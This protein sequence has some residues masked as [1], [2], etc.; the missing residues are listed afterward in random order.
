M[1]NQTQ[2]QQRRSSSKG[3]AT[4]ANKKTT[5]TP[6][7]V[8][9]Q[10]ATPAG[11]TKRVATTILEQAP[12]H[13]EAKSSVLISVASPDDGNGNA[14]LL[15]SRPNSTPPS[16]NSQ[17]S[18]S[19]SS[20]L[21]SSSSMAMPMAGTANVTMTVTSASPLGRPHAIR[22]LQEEQDPWKAV[23]GPGRRASYAGARQEP[24]GFFFDDQ[25]ENAI[26]TAARRSITAPPPGFDASQSMGASQDAFL[27]Q[28]FGG[29]SHGQRSFSFSAGQPDQGATGSV[30][31]TGTSSSDENNWMLQRR[32]SAQK[33]HPGQQDSQRR[34]SKLPATVE[35]SSS[36]AMEL[37][38]PGARARSKSSSNIFAGIPHAQELFGSREDYF[39]MQ[40]MSNIWNNGGNGRMLG[41]PRRT[42]HAV[43][44]QYQRLGGF[45]QQ[46]AEAR[47]FSVATSGAMP[48]DTTFDTHDLATRYFNRDPSLM[49][50][51]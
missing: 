23:G 2:Q 24:T 48:V 44:P 35:E 25:P 22:K 5:V 46:H 26:S 41:G 29:R 34:G 49:E 30:P 19:S 1:M 4:P 7:T 50:Q 8:V 38:V 18:S 27:F 15:L 51:R 31:S 33:Q 21:S 40:S 20:L 10:A 17:L 12:V 45:P 37:S 43:L 6:A 28:F 32:L 39:D 14:G 11:Q 47:R 16:L 42:T 9:V 36:A 3:A 13:V